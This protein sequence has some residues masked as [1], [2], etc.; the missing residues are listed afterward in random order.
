MLDRRLFL[1]AALGS[2]AA[3]CKSPAPVGVPATAPTPSAAPPPTSGAEAQ[4]NALFDTFVDET[5]TRRPEILTSL[6]LDK[7]KYAWARSKLSDESLE[8]RRQD[9]VENADR[10]RRLQAFDRKL[11]SGMALANYD[12][13]E[14]QLETYARRAPFDYGDGVGPYVVTQLRGSYRDTPDFLDRQ[15]RIESG[16]DAEAYL[17]RLRQLAVVIDQETERVVHDAGLRVVPPDFILERTLQQL[18]ALRAVPPAKSILTTSLATR[19]AKLGLP[20]A[21]GATAAQIVG[22]EIYPAIDRQIAAIEKLQ[23]GAVHEAGIR[24]LPQG[25]ELYQLALR[26]YTTTDMSAEEVHRLGVEQARELASKMDAILRSQGLTQGSVGQRVKAL[27][28]D[29]K[30]LFPNTDAGR[31][32]ILD[33]CNRIIAELQPRLGDYFG[34]LPKTPV[35]VRRVPV[36]TEAGSP[37]G[38]YQRPALDGSR[39]GAFYINLRDTA[40]LA[41]W[42]LPTLVYHEAAP[43]HHF[44]LA[45]V[46][47]LQDLPLIRKLGFFSANTEG[48]ALYAEQLCEEMGL[49]QDDPLG[50]LGRLQAAIFR[51]ARC[52]VDTG[53]HTQ[54]WSREK[55]IEY[56]VETTGDHD[57]AMTT[58]VER[59]CARPGQA[60]SYKIGHTMWVKL[61]EDARTRLGEKFDIREFHDTGLTA[62]PMPLSVLE[63]VIDDWV[64]KEVA[65]V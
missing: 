12:T 25:P 6:G 64:T 10:L 2:L 60:T 56:M 29:P 57:A 24:R 51:A 38:Y 62:G 8:R 40:E 19:T 36:Y 26:Q 14:F 47:E 33:Y 7:G 30:H 49:Y 20:A 23:P 13:V 63:R 18:R 45:L 11:L 34:V 41:R 32:Q 37:G 21:H 50:Q 28:S 58:E 1:T 22:A 46:T 42:T 44:Q 54:G 55:A 43:G 65:H 61:R 35:E 16:E 3:A 9:I 31:Q 59:Y 4:L 17:S 52:V 15:H 53:L 5:L 39:P 27:G 48:W